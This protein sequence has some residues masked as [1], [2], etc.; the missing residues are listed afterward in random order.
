ML[1][2]HAGALLDFIEQR[3]VP[4]THTLTPTV[5]RRFYRERRF[6]AQAERPPVAEVSELRADG[7]NGAIPLRLYK[8]LFS[9]NDNK[10]SIPLLP[11]LVY[12][13]GGGWV[14]GDLDTHDTLCREF[15][16]ATGCAVAAVDYRVAPEHHFPAAVEDCVTATYWVQGE[17]G[18]LGLDVSRLNWKA[19]R[20]EPEGVTWR[21]EGMMRVQFHH[22]QMGLLKF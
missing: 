7:P 17:D 1:P 21:L 14:S 20:P 12:F 18:E 15:A 2:P 8:P 5:A 9:A 13:H 6:V 11:V 22:E 10:P 16:N 3:G 4:A 19:L